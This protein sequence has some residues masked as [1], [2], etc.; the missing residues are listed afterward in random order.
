MQFTTLISAFVFAATAL[1]APALVVDSSIEARDGA[2]AWEFHPFL[3]A[4][5]Q[6]P[7]SNT[8]GGSQAPGSQCINVTQRYG[9]KV[10]SA[11]S[12]QGCKVYAFLN[13]NTDCS[14]TPEPATSNT[15]SSY[16][17]PISSIRVEC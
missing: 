17:T 13:G 7:T 4:S 15:C 1:A 8:L 3:D 16:P 9:D 12:T 11:A 10:Y 6:T 14:G 2:T 5:C